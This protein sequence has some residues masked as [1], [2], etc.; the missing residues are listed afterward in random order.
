MTSRTHDLMRIGLEPTARAR[1]R[2]NRQSV[3]AL[4]LIGPCLLFLLITFAVPIAAMLFRSI[5]D[6]E[7]ADTLPHTAA[8]FQAWD[9]VGLPPENL[10]RIFA[11]DV[12]AAR[13]TGN[14][15]VAGS[16]GCGRRRGYC[17]WR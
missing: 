7:L 8:A 9:G 16:R 6:P 17:R 12:A 4:M 1:L 13:E 11:Q 10:V 15:G 14:I 5:E 2:V 3:H